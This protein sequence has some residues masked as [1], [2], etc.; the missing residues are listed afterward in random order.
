MPEAK[1]SGFSVIDFERFK[2][3]KSINDVF[4]S[5]SPTFKHY[6]IIL[7]DCFISNYFCGDVLLRTGKSSIMVCRIS[8]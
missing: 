8:E 1:T 5:F 2:K 7:G 3:N 6:L 4:L